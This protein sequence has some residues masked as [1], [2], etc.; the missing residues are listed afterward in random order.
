MIYF[1]VP[2]GD[3]EWFNLRKGV[4]TASR[5]DNIITPKT[6]EISKSAEKYAHELIGEMITGENAEKFTSYWMERGAAMEADARMSYQALTDLDIDRGGFM[7]N[8]DLTNGASADL[9]VFDPSTGKMIGGTEIK[10][11]MAATHLDNIFRDGKID[12]QYNPQ[13]QGQILRYGFEFV[14]WFSYHPDMIP[15]LVRTYREDEY[16]AKLEKALAEFDG[17]I[18]DKIETLIKKG[19]LV[20]DR[21]ILAINHA[22]L[23]PKIPTDFINA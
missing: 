12:P 3:V 21:P 8:D 13:V 7:A 19:Q 18:K 20:P 4:A 22:R 6:G 2:Q 14:D 10:C 15:A 1:D 16:C 5:Y 23:N 9:R 17:M 11:P